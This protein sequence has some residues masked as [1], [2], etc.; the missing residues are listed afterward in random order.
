MFSEMKSRELQDSR[1][2]RTNWFPKGHDIECFVI[3]LD[4]YFSVLQEQ[5]ICVS[6]K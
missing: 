5:Q 4:F 2:N 6:V 3:F 1:E